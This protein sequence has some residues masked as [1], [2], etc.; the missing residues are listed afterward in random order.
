MYLGNPQ[1]RFWHI[2]SLLR[3]TQMGLGSFMPNK[4]FKWTGFARRLI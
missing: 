4:A 2:V 3:L 1:Q